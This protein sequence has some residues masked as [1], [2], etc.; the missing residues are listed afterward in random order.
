M[1]KTALEQAFDYATVH[2]GE[3]L[4]PLTAEEELLADIDKRL[5]HLGAPAD[6]SVRDLW[7]RLHIHVAIHK[8]D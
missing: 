5:Q 1:A 7:D 6:P 4:Y 8:G 2:E 3:V